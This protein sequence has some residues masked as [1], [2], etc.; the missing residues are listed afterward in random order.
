MSNLPTIPGYA[1]KR[2]IGK[3][4]MGEV[5]LAEQTSLGRQVAMKVMLASLGEQDEHFSDRF[6]REAKTTASLRHPNIITVYDTGEYAGRCYMTMD[7]IEGGS[8]RDRIG[9]LTHRQAF[10][11]CAGVAAGLAKAHAS[12]FVHRDIKPENI[13]LE[14]TGNPVITDFGIVKVTYSTTELTGTHTVGSPTY[15]S[16]E[17]LLGDAALDGRA[18]LYSLGVV[19]YEMLEGKPPFQSDAAYGVGMKHLNEDPPPLG[20]EHALFQDLVSRL[21]EKDPSRRHQSAGDVIADLRQI[22]EDVTRGVRPTRR[23]ETEASPSASD[24]DDTETAVRNKATAQDDRDTAVRTPVREKK[25]VTPEPVRSTPFREGPMHEDEAPVISRRV[26][27]KMISE[28]APV[29]DY[30]PR[31]REPNIVARV[32]GLWPVKALLLVGALW[33]AASVL[34]PDFSINNINLEFRALL[35]EP[36]ERE[37]IAKRF[38]AMGFPGRARYWLKKAAEGGHPGASYEL[39]LSYASDQEAKAIEAFEAEIRPFVSDSWDLPAELMLSEALCN[40]RSVENCT[41]AITILE[42]IVR[43]HGSQRAMLKLGEIYMERLPRRD[44]ETAAEWLNR[45]VMESETD[46]PRTAEATEALVRL[47]TLYDAG[48]GVSQ[49]REAATRYLALAAQSPVAREA[50]IREARARCAEAEPR[51]EACRSLE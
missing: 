42:R 37:R 36:A 21:L 7:F 4:G 16:P 3:G 40:G 31:M 12:G 17:Q 8:L 14:L 19:L 45:I 39:G 25:P 24:A 28:S 23:M 22:R 2:R 11:I 5:Y 43:Q 41:R 35:A 18:D 10:R 47:A 48:Q 33:T 32:L 44:Y 9:R 20:R 50:N 26:T 1:I 51:P 29:A 46:P 13:L 30:G 6:E 38:N 34:I 49:D 27:R 15:M